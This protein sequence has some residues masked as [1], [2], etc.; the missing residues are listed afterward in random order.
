[1]TFLE[2]FGLREQPFG[3]T[4]D[5]RFFYLNS[6]N[7]EAFA[8]LLYGIQ[9][10]RGF[11]A[12]I[13]KPGLGK[14]TLLF[15]IEEELGRTAH[16]AFLSRI[17]SSPVELLRCL[18]EDLGE[19]PRSLALDGL[20]GQ[21]NDVLIRESRLGR[22]VVVLIDEAQQ[23]DYASLEMLRMLSNF[24]TPQTK[25]LQLVLAGQ[26]ELA[27]RLADPRLVQLRQRISVFCYLTP[28]NAGQV[29]SYI[30]HR[31][32][33]AGYAESDPLFTSKALEAVAAHSGG[34]PRNVNNLCFHAL[35]L[36]FVKRQKQIDLATLQEVMSDLDWE[37][38]KSQFTPDGKSN[39]M[40]MEP[41]TSEA[42][43]QSFGGD[44]PRRAATRTSIAKRLQYW[45]AAI[46]LVIALQAEILWTGSYAKSTLARAHRYWSLAISYI[47]GN[48]PNPTAKA[49][50]N[51]VSKSGPLPNGE[52]G[53]P[54]AGSRTVSSKSEKDR[55]ASA[56]LAS[57]AVAGNID[58]SPDGENADS[59]NSSVSIRP[60]SPPGSVSKPNYPSGNGKDAIKQRE[61]GSVKA[62]LLDAQP[63]VF[64]IE[65][66]PLG[67]EIFIDGQ[68]YGRSRVV[69]T[70]P[71]GLHKWK[72]YLAP[73]YPP[74][75]SDI[76]L[77]AGEV[78]TKTVFWSSGSVPRIEGGS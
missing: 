52:S 6:E 17:Y 62:D 35:C 77:R 13:A 53:G 73:G 50:L 33:S 12:L 75:E 44:A 29:A 27:D 55:G 69:A 22:Q 40:K 14:T 65:T 42:P 46:L 60:N 61:S 10:K 2:Y 48:L 49:S 32:R 63:A 72:V 78:S 31:L 67:M 66:Q 56:M 16:T 45:A 36:G 23:L 76:N 74:V 25:L 38:A 3:V 30:D 9:A 19:D 41:A 51:A 64:V 47:K 8:S 58:L 4:P 1:L 20:Q 54:I 26:P 11:L 5:P 15:R 68:L 37:K 21:L 59:E 43:A 7:R 71:P 28:L 70:L 24:E 34:I 57:A 39:A 18:L